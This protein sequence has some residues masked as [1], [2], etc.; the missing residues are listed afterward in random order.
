MWVVVVDE[1]CAL[2]GSEEVVKFSFRADDALERAETQQ[3]SLAYVRDDAKV[4]QHNLHQCLDFAWV[5][6]AHLD[7]SNVM[8]FLELQESL[9]HTDVVVE[10]ALRVKHIV[11]LLQYGGNQFFRG[12]LTVRT[13]DADDRCTQVDTVIFRQLLQGG[14]HILHQNQPFVT[15]FCVFFLVNHGIG[16]TLFQRSLRIGIAV[17]CLTLQGKKHRILRHIAAVGRDGRML[18]KNIV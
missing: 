17:E 7:D 5:V 9:W 18:Q 15:L 1:C 4:G 14:E 8:F 12:R 13:C 3:V 11:F 2:N 6:C 10:V 16:C